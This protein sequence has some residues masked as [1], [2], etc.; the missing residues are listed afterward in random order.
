MKPYDSFEQHQHYDQSGNDVYQD[1]HPQHNEK[2]SYPVGDKWEKRMP[3][4]PGPSESYHGGGQPKPPQGG[5]GPPYMAPP[6]FTPKLTGGM[7]NAIDPGSMKGCLYQN[8]YVWLRNGRSFWFYPTYV[9][10]NSV[11]GYRWRNSQQRW[12]YYGTDA[13]EIQAFQCF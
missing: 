4:P 11:A 2:Y 12:S 1:V 6:L 10:Y 3:G 9:G 13:S 5:G 7:L 8:T